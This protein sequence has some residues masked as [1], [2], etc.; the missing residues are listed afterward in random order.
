MGSVSPVYL[1]YLVC[2]VYLVNQTHDLVIWLV[3]F[4]PNKQKTNQIN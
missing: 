4:R 2:L 3:S 1:V